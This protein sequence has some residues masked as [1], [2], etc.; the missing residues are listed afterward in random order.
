M[1]VKLLLIIITELSC[2]VCVWHK[3][4]IVDHGN[5]VGVWSRGRVLVNLLERGGSYITIGG[6]S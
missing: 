2:I 4:L 5:Q 3:C 6:T 1:W